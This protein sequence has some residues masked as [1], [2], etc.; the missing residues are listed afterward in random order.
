MSSL[1]LTVS[2]HRCTGLHKSM[3]D[4]QSSESVANPND[5]SI[6]GYVAA[7]PSQLFE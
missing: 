4:D 5:R 2:S 1:L 3:L 7:Q 6:A